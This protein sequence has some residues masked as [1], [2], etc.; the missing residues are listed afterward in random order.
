MESI[1]QKEKRCFICGRTGELDEHHLLSGNSNRGN[2][3]K[4]K[5][6]IYICRACHGGIHDKGKFEKDAKMYA[7]REWEKKY[8]TREEFIK[9]FGKSWL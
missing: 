7:Q 9:I 3:T 4:Y 2:S 5:L 1:L 8:G 6:T